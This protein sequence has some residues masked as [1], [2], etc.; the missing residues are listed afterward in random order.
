MT[1]WAWDATQA[2]PDPQSA[3]KVKAFLQYCGSLGYF[4]AEVGRAIRDS[5]TKTDPPVRLGHGLDNPIE[6]PVGARPGVSTDGHLLIVDNVTGRWHD[7]ELYKFA[8]G[9]ITSVTNGISMPIGAVRE[10]SGKGSATAAKFPLARGVVTPAQIAAG[11]IP[12]ALVFTAANLGPAPNPYPAGSQVGYTTGNLG[13]WAGKSVAGHIPLGTWIRMKASAAI[14]SA[15]PDWEQIFFLA[16]QE[17]GALCRD[18]GSTVAFHGM[19]DGGGGASFDAWVAAGVPF[20]KK[21]DGSSSMAARFQYM[22]WDQLEISL[23]PAAA[24]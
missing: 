7:I 6:I 1:A 2:K 14:S 4:T 9:K 24:S 18:R 5:Q 3:A 12:H 11:R 21:A 19:D 22:P 8:G 16:L 17:F 15:A 13:A 20:T 10:P 23:P